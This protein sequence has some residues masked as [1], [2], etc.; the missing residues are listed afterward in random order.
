MMRHLTFEM[1][2]PLPK[3]KAS[4][5]CVRPYRVGYSYRRAYHHCD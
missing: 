3:L 4:I 1:T 2:A 5:A